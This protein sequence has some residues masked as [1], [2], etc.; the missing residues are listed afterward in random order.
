ME[1]TRASAQQ[2]HMPNALTLHFAVDFESADSRPSQVQVYLIS[3]PECLHHKGRQGVVIVHIR[4][5]AQS[6]SVEVWAAHLEVLAARASSH[7]LSHLLPITLWQP[8]HGV[9]G[10]C[11]RPCLALPPE[12]LI[13]WQGAMSLTT[14]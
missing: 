4:L 3:G 8:A 11:N 14:T 13:L 9:R 6:Y 7:L 2:H 1:P 5:Q 12:L 10:V